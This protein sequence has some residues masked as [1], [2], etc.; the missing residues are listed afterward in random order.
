MYESP[1]SSG[2]TNDE[3]TH[4]KRTELGVHRSNTNHRSRH[5]HITNSHPFPTDRT[6]HQVLSQE[7]KHRGKRQAKQI[8]FYRRINLPA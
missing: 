5:V 2:H 8:L 3:R 6:A 7:R 4:R 1:Q